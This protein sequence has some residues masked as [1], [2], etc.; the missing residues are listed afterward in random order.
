[1]KKTFSIEY[2]ERMKEVNNV[3]KKYGIEQ[4]SS[5]QY[6]NPALKATISKWTKAENTEAA[7]EALMAVGRGSEINALLKE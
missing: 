6:E 5:D 1:M 2:K 4:I 3:L 7:S